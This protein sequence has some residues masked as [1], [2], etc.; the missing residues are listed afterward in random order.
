[1]FEEVVGFIRGR[2]GGRK[3]IPLHE[4]CFV[5]SEKKYV[6]DCIDSTFV[7]SVG[8]YVNDFEKKLEDFT[9]AEKAIATSNGT[10][11][12]HVALV[13]AGVQP[14]TE[15]LTQALTF[16]AT[17][18]AI[19]YCGAEPI[20]LDSDL[21]RLSLSAEAVSSFL[22]TNGEVRNDGLCYNKK[23]GRRIVACL[24]MHVFG[25]PADLLNLKIVC[26]KFR[27]K[28]VEDAAES[29][30]SIYM[31][32]HTGLIGDIGVLSFNGNKIITTGGGGAVIVKDAA[33]GARIK[34][35]TTTAK[36]PHAWEFYHDEIGYN[37]RL[38]NLNAALGCA[39][40]EGL[41]GF[42]TN[43]RQTFEIYKEFFDKKGIE[44]VQEPKDSKSN[45][46]LNAI[47]LK[48]KNERDN[49]LEIT[50]RNGIMTR[51]AWT[52]MTELPMYKSKAHDELKNARSLVSRLVNIPSSV[53]P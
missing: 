23:S 12:L 24:P 22:D 21:H 31:N 25:H 51:P 45:Y 9:G 20:F 7:S 8:K 36:R 32:K 33:L 34:H 3:E 19:S 42:L 30:G 29:L 17:A 1:M 46:W 43:K 27:I 18:N 41:P 47:L 14:G 49:F 53:R 48:D 6:D 11:A 50:N 37:Y 44:M 13:V 5:G 35:L 26:E 15:V 52:L 38:P 40:M 39:Q 28:L 4:P 16:V 2:Y 10:S